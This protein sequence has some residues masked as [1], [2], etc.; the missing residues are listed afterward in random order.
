[1]YNRWNYWSFKYYAHNGSK[2]IIYKLNSS[3][4]VFAGDFEFDDGR[5]STNEVRFYEFKDGNFCF[6][7]L[8]SIR[9]KN[10][11]TNGVMNE[12]GMGMSTMKYLDIHTSLFPFKGTTNHKLDTHN[13][14]AYLVVVKSSCKSRGVWIQLVSAITRGSL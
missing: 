10:E 13:L 12:R 3:L 8:L 1:M 4:I 11:H 7:K 9:S 5:K 14:L 2:E 6:W